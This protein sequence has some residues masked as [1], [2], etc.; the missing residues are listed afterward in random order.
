MPEA[1]ER[2]GLF[3]Q[4]RQYRPRQ[5]DGFIHNGNE[6]G[7]GAN[8]LPPQPNRSHNGSGDQYDPIR[9]GRRPPAG[10]TWILFRLTPRG[11]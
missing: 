11:S 9:L 6:F 8:F 7:T 10:A 4:L 3:L 1:G 5:R 2:T